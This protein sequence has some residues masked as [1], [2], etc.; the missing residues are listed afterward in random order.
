MFNHDILR[1]VKLP[2]QVAKLQKISQPLYDQLD[3][4]GPGKFTYFKG[5]QGRSRLFTN[6]DG[7]SQLDNP[8]HYLVAGIRV[9]PVA[10]AALPDIQVLSKRGY[11]TLTVGDKPFFEA[12]LSLLLTRADTLN[13]YGEFR[14]GFYSLDHPI[15]LPPQQIFKPSIDIENPAVLSATVP[16]TLTFEGVLMRPAQ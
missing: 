12:P 14:D 7:Q 13:L 15:L 11:F 2:D 8:R 5:A 9:Q 6:F 1:H 16:L 10:D 4:T 3:I